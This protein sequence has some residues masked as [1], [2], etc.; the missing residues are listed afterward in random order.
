VR[1]A[2]LLLLFTF[3]I[4]WSDEEGT[5]LKVPMQGR[6]GYIVPKE[7]MIKKFTKNKK[8]DLY[9]VPIFGGDIS[10]FWTPTIEQVKAADVAVADCL[11]E[12]GNYEAL[13]NDRDLPPGKFRDQEVQDHLEELPIVHKNYEKY[14]VQYW[15]ITVAGERRI[16]C[17]YYFG[18]D[19]PMMAKELIYIFDAGISLWQIQCD[20]NSNHVHKLEISDGSL[21][22]TP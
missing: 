9:H 3:S 8:G 16:F 11:K 1:I 10:E 15:G 4:A 12:K 17:N 5:F 13:A 21:K 14:Q 2:I 7:Y 18:P 22:L 6:V 19:E 20:V